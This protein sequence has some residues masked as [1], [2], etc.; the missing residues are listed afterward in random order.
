MESYEHIPMVEQPVDMKINLYP[1]QLAS[2]YSMEKLESEKKITTDDFE[3]ST[4]L[5][6][7]SDMTGYGKSLSIVALVTRNKME[8]DTN[9]EEITEITR[10]FSD[11]LLQRIT[12]TYCPRID[13][14]LILVGPSVIHQWASEFKYSPLR[15]CVV[16]NKK[17][18]HGLD[19]NKTDVVLVIPSMFNIITERVHGVCWKRFIF[20][21]PSQLRVPGM[22]KIQAGFIWLVTATPEGIAPQHR[23]C[24]TSY[25]SRIVENWY[26]FEEN[27]EYITIENDNDF[28]Q[29]SFAMP[30]TNHHFHECRSE[31]FK[32]LDGLVDDR[33]HSMI[34]GGDISGAI[35]AMGGKTTDNLT[36][37]VRI[38]KN[39]I[40]EDIRSHI[41]YWETESENERE[42]EEKIRVWSS[43][44]KEILKQL[45]ELDK[46]VENM[47]G[48]DCVICQTKLEKPVMEPLCQSIF[49]G[50]CLLTWLKEKG[51]CPNCRGKIK[52]SDLVYIEKKEDKENE[53]DE[54]NQEENKLPTKQD[55][56]L[57]LIKD[58]KDGKFIIFS[59]W[60]NT[61]DVIR[62]V[63][64]E[65]NIKFY[66][67]K[68]AS[69]NR[70]KILE[71]FKNGKVRVLFLNSKFNGAGIN[72]Q[73]TTDIILYHKMPPDNQKQVI[74]RANRIGRDDSLHVHHL[75]YEKA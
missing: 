27:R 9:K 65:N 58:K 56:V 29:K 6:I 3:L 35:R 15:V 69:A 70:Q 59:D 57:N 28:L 67:V 1:H 73:E 63:L 66:E 14:T 16:N 4:K 40:L 43:R 25:M 7:H 36:D 11:N 62:R 49:C 52:K 17:S 19:I 45:Q 50:K 48:N 47:L 31:V 34:D 54:E 68:G 32:V 39:H 13:T 23:R 64:K 55:K 53:V 24:R 71:K 38:K 26:H 41:R 10:D 33:I 75:V 61:F 46:R 30:V 20:D 44:E 37:L 21:E 2:V 12:K 8:W 5:G 72:L 60:D 74:G 42:K 22:K 51:T 18:I